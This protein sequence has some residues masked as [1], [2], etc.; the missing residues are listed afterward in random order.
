MKQ[1]LADHVDEIFEQ[2]DDAMATVS[3]EASSRHATTGAI[4]YAASADHKAWIEHKVQHVPVQSGGTAPSKSHVFVKT[5]AKLED[6]ITMP[7]ATTPPIVA[8]QKHLKNDGTTH[9][10]VIFL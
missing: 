2:F 1:E 8:V 10:S 6:R 9:F 7:D 4:E 5:D 3:L